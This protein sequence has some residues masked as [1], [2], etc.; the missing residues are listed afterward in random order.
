MDAF[1]GLLR[2]VWDILTQVLL[3]AK[4]RDTRKY[5]E[6]GLSIVRCA[7]VATETPSEGVRGSGSRAGA[8]LCGNGPY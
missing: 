4:L 6:I 1:L 2:T 5:V 8:D 3:T 7:E